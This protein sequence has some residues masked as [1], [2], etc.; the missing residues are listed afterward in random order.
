MSDE[1]NALLPDEL[2]INDESLAKQDIR[3][4][5]PAGTSCYWKIIEGSRRVNAKSNNLELWAR[6]IPLYD[7][8]DPD[9][10]GLK[11]FALNHRLTL[12]SA[13]PKVPGHEAPKTKGF[14][15]EFL[16]AVF[17]EEV[18]P[19][20]GWNKALRK[21]TFRG[22]PVSKEEAEEIRHKINQATA[23]KLQEA[24]RDPSSL[25]GYCFV[26]T[27][28]KKGDYTQLTQLLPEPRAGEPLTDLSDYAPASAVDDD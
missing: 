8:S 26:A 9:T 21:P 25:I 27:I 22:D 17:G 10:S 7:P 4:T 14:A 2:P 11:K 16:R 1:N 28:E 23:E 6:V 15:V 18:I 5:L 19:Y 20:L 12:P 3:E 24:Y 13:N